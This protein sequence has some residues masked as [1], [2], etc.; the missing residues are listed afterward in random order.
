MVENC[1][2]DGA[3]CCGGKERGKIGMYESRRGGKKN[4]CKSY[5]AG[6]GKDARVALRFPTLDC[7][8]IE[9]GERGKKYCRY[10]KRPRKR[11]IGS[12]AYARQDREH[13][14]GGEQSANEKLFGKA[15]SEPCRRIAVGMDTGEIGKG[16]QGKD[17][18]ALTN[19]D[20]HLP[21]Y[22]SGCEASGG[23][24][25]D[26]EHV[27]MTPVKVMA[28]AQTLPIA[29]DE[30]GAGVEQTIANVDGPGSK[31]D[32]ERNPRG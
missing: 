3:G 15:G 18:V 25:E 7:V 2:Q 20:G 22:E 5:Q 4:S 32:E 30:A 17:G 8:A 27:S 6:G 26:A 16:S 9:P 13:T 14:T 10:Q 12:G 11:E 21:E 28:L 29:G 24:G 31:R 1:K 23:R 19:G